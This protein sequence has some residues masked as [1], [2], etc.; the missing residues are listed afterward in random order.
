VDSP[1]FEWYPSRPGYGSAQPSGSPSYD[2]GKPADNYD[3]EPE[4]GDDTVDDEPIYDRQAQEKEKR[5]S[6]RFWG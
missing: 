5:G 2:V 6:W 4:Y 3:E 1:Y